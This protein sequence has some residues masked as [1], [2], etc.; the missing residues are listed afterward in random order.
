MYILP[1]NAKKLKFSV[2]RRLLLLNG[3]NTIV[4]GLST[5]Q[6]MPVFHNPIGIL[7]IFLSNFL[8]FKIA[9][10]ILIGILILRYNKI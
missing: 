4:L 5:C 3:K 8:F 9:N 7:G 10:H 1:K 6:R 2:L